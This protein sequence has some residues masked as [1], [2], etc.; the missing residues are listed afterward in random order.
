MPTL[1]DMSDLGPPI[2]TNSGRLYIGFTALAFV[3]VTAYTSRPLA[4]RLLVACLIASDIYL[5]LTMPDLMGHIAGF[6]PLIA[7]FIVAD[8]L[9]VIDLYFIRD[10]SKVFAK[11]HDGIV[12]NGNGKRS[13]E[14]QKVSPKFLKM[15]GFQAFDY[16]IINHRNIGTPY[17]VRNI[18]TFSSSNP[19]YIP[20]RSKFLLRK[21]ITIFAAYLTLDL[22]TCQPAPDPGLYSRHQ[23][24][25]F[26]RLN[27]VT[28]AEIRFRLLTNLNLWASTFLLIQYIYAIVACV[29]V[30]SFLYE[31]RDF[32][33]L[34]GSLEHCYTVRN[35]W[36]YISFMRP[37]PIMFG[38]VYLITV[39]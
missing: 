11:K 21:F 8:L 24:F 31:P 37:L 35:H 26:T 6:D 33:P 22:M 10:D 19:S 18:P 16:L 34:I 5:L 9:R 14:K 23:E 28:W 2:S 7:N 29:C 1:D 13:D 32:P 27:E 38:D 39:E 3:V 12:V 4:L 20:S 17:A 30:G 15:S 36:G 25:F